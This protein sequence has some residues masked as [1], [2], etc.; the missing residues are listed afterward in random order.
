MIVKMWKPQHQYLNVQEY[1]IMQ[2]Q[3]HT[4]YLKYAMSH[5]KIFHFFCFQ[6]KD[7]GKTQRQ[8]RSIIATIFKNAHKYLRISDLKQQS[9]V[10]SWVKIEFTAKFVVY[11]ILHRIEANV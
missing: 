1:G 9:F 8:K 6:E 4:Y 10:Y 3:N 5:V 7:A 11:Y 2:M